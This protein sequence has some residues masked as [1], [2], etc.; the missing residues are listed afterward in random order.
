VW[1]KGFQEIKVENLNFLEPS[2][3]HQACNG[4]HDNG[5]GWW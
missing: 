1:P 5:T 4:F 2:G 3:P